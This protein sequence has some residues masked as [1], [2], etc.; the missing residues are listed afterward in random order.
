VFLVW[1]SAAV[2]VVGIALPFSPLCRYLGFA[3]LPLLYWPLL[4]LTLVGYVVLTQA[5]KTM[6]LR[7]PMDLN[8]RQPAATT[9]R[10]TMPRRCPN[11]AVV[12]IAAPPPIKTRR[13]ARPIGAPPSCPPRAPST[14]RL[15]KLTSAIARMR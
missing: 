10:L 9:T 1:T 4:G 5:A 6:L 15:A 11:S 13:D 3:R 8:P 12:A 2:I 14:P 7:S